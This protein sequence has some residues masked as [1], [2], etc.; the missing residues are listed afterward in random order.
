MKQQET[1]ASAIPQSKTQTSERWV[2]KKYRK[3]DTGANPVKECKLD[4]GNRT[5]KP[6]VLVSHPGNAGACTLS[7]GPITVAASGRRCVS[8]V[9]LKQAN[10]GKPLQQPIE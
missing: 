7:L 5:P 10:S 6:P 9:K 1:G 2:S 4:T 8:A 3:L